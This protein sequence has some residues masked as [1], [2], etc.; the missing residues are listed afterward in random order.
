M[1]TFELPDRV[2][3]LFF[4]RDGY[5]WSVVLNTVLSVSHSNGGVYSHT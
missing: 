4:S 2:I 3:F 1:W 5:I